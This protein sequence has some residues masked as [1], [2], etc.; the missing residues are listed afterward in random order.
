[1]HHRVPGAPRRAALP[2]AG[3]LLATAALTACNGAADGTGPPSPTG[4]TA[5]P[6]PTSTLGSGP[7]ASPGVVPDLTGDTV[8]EARSRLADLD[9]GM[10]FTDGSGIGD[11][12]LAVT[13]QSPAPGTRAASGTTVTLTVPGD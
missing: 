11:D 3:L 6:S 5:S 2:L 10:A 7:A 12:S 8:A 9:Y 4:A 1:M 13:A